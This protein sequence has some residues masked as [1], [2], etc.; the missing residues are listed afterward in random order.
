MNYPNY[1]NITNIN[2]KL[3]YINTK[4]KKRIKQKFS[5][6]FLSNELLNIN[7]YLKSDLPW[8]FTK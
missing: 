2:I 5:V 4:N 6:T 3:L 7:Y 8:I 1:K